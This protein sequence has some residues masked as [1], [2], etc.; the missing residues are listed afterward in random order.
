MK[1]QEAQPFVSLE[2]FR[3]NEKADRYRERALTLFALEQELEEGP[4]IF[5]WSPLFAQI[6]LPHRKVNGTVWEVESQ[7]Y[8]LRISSGFE[9][10]Y[11]C[12]PRLLLSYI[13]TQII[14]TDSPIIS[15]GKNQNQFFEMLGLEKDGRTIRRFNQQALNL[16]RSMIEIEIKPEAGIS[17][18]SGRRG[19]LFDWIHISDRCVFWENIEATHKKTWLGELQVSSKFFD[20]VKSKGGIPF[21]F[22][23]YASL[24]KS[25]MAMDLYIWLPYRLFI[26]QQQRHYSVSL[27]FPLLQKQFDPNS[28]LSVR[29]FKIKFLN[30]LSMVMPHYTDFYDN[31]KL[32]EDGKH[33]V[34]TKPKKSVEAVLKKDNESL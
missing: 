15:L 22:H 34:L 23:R 25:S 10:P 29:D 18:S 32:S 14:K 4:K 24:T 5:F 8:A 16:F 17:D 26:L 1:K 30:C 19:N 2:K 9:L 28:S 27:Q 11:G 21:N 7:K 6:C 31:V 3:E 20:F 33:L 12:F 13:T